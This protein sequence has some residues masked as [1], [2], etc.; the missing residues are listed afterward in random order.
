MR[1]TL[2]EIPGIGKVVVCASCDRIHFMYGRITLDLNREE[3]LGL[4]ELIS[5]A[6]E[7]LPF[8]KNE[9]HGADKDR[10]LVA[11]KAVMVH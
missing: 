9:I 11:G 2:A 3:L 10:I 8:G 5:N 1:K 4:K 6:V 7:H